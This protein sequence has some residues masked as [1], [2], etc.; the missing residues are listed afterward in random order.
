MNIEGIFGTV[1]SGRTLIF[2]HPQNV[3][4]SFADILSKH[5]NLQD[6]IKSMPLKLSDNLRVPRATVEQR[7][8]CM[9]CGMTISDEGTCLCEYPTVITKSGTNLK[10]NA[11]AADISAQPEG[12]AVNKIQN[13]SDNNQSHSTKDIKL[14]H[15]CPRCG[16]VSDDGNCNCDN[17]KCDPISKSIKFKPTKQ[18][19]NTISK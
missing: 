3:D 13:I 10:H 9:L 6:A 11:A 2:A 8:A 1:K 14:R 7:P 17:S 16:T 15:K 19:I 18:T 12:A 5:T 4:V